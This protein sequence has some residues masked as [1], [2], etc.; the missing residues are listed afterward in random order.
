MMEITSHK[1]FLHKSEC[2]EEY[3]QDFVDCRMMFRNRTAQKGRISLNRE[4]LPDNRK[5]TLTL[6]AHPE[7]LI[8][9]AMLGQKG[10][11]MQAGVT[12]TQEF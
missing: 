7:R 10:A 1:I 6:T 8:N 3:L 5:L 2:N 4:K 12:Y 11:K 9:M